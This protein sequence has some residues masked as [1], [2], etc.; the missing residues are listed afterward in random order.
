MQIRQ[1]LAIDKAFA[2]EIETKKVEP[3]IV[4][5]GLA[6]VALVGDN[7][8]NHP[9]ISGK[10]FGVLGRNGVNIRAIAQGSSERNISAVI[11]TG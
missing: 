11:A 8:K 10:M 7:M 6:I 5:R 2:Y 9:G 4:E 3:L 1:K